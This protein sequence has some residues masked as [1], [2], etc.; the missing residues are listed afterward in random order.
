M[1]SLQQNL[2]S[3]PQN[4]PWGDSMPNNPPTKTS[5]LTLNSLC[6]CGDLCTESLQLYSDDYKVSNMLN[7][8]LNLMYMVLRDWGVKISPLHLFLHP[9]HLH[10]LVFNFC[11]DYEVIIDPSLNT[12]LQNSFFMSHCIHFLF[13][14]FGLLHSCG[15]LSEGHHLHGPFDVVVL[16]LELTHLYL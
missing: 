14:C 12:R 11:C 6:Q 7:S 8:L 2:G 9:L 13:Q 5:S 10:E 15:P 3:E 16:L 4:M 1:E